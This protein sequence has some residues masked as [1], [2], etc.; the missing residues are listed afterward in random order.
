M[1]DFAWFRLAVVL[2][3]VALAAFGLP[4]LLLTVSSFLAVAYPSGLPTAQTITWAM[5]NGLG[6]MLQ[7]ALGVFL[8]LRAHR[9]AAYFIKRVKGRCAACDFDLNGL[10]NAEV[11]PKCGSAVPAKPAATS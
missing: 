6:P 11:C 2:L 1:R 7:T 8:V 4:A 10:A 5:L 9:V 3:G